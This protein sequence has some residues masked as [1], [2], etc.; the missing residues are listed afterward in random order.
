MDRKPKTL[1]LRW[2][3]A[4]ACVTRMHLNLAVMCRSQMCTRGDLPWL[5]VREFVEEA[6]AVNE[7]QLVDNVRA[8]SIFVPMALCVTRGFGVHIRSNSSPRH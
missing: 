7:A 1:C 2:L 4:S 3:M 5:V 6:R 8:L